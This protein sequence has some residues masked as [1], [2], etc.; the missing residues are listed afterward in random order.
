M[1]E[2]W[3]DSVDSEALGEGAYDSEALG[4]GAYDSE[5]FGEGYEAFG[6]ES[7]SARRQRERQRQIMLAR[8]RQAQLRRQR[9]PTQVQRPAPP[10][11]PSPR[12]TITAIRSLDLETKVGQDSLRRALEESN[13]RAAR[14][15]WAAVASAAVDQGL[16]SFG[17]DLDNHEYI[18][19]GARF[20]P[21]LFLS[22]EKTRRGVEGFVTDPRV[23]GG[24]AIV[25]IALLGNFRTRS[26]GIAS[27]RIVPPTGR[28]V[29]PV[30][31][32][33]TST[34]TANALDRNGKLV[35]PQPPITWSSSDPATLAFQDSAT[36]TF[37]LTAGNTGTVQITAQGG[38]FSDRLDVEVRSRWEGITSLIIDPPTATITAPGAG[39]STGTITASALDQNGKPLSTQPMIKWS[40]SDPDTMAFL[41]RSSGTYTLTAGQTGKVKIM[42]QAE[43]FSDKLTVTVK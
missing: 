40:S 27:L 21:L 5:A 20:A 2:A 35:I 37:T 11:G 38:G 24:A 16:D 8:Q 22:P 32:T 7:R 6:E 14:A 4:E 41:D 18:K 26:Q 3:V 28:I 23:L 42:A 15:T 34:I 1:S 12:Q 39:T 36:G 10:A 43:G 33:S 30:T 29:A 31:G 19:A 25:G 17:A 13:R 9:Q